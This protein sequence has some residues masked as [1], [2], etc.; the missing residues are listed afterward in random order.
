MAKQTDV[1]V[2]NIELWGRHIGYVAWDDNRGTSNFSYTK[3]FLQS[4]IQLS[5]FTM[6]LS[7]QVYSFPELSRDSYKG[8]PGLLA[9]SLPDKFGMI[10][11]KEWLERQGRTLESFSP[12][13][14]LCYMG[15]RGMGALEY[16]PQLQQASW[17]DT[18]LELSSLVDLA[19]KAIAQKDQLSTNFSEDSAFNDILRVGTSA[20]GARAKAIIAWIKIPMRY[21]VVI[22][23]MIRDLATGS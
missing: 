22:L 15:K 10:L 2:V 21:E 20:G 9:D 19:N 18:Q 12:I 8:L 1:N 4:N 17:S 13:E 5:P 6:P 7:D 3:E 11:I 23:H 14:R 16:A